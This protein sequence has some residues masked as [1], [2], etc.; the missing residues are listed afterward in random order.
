MNSVELAK[1]VLSKL[2][3]VGFLVTEDNGL[4][5][6]VLDKAGMRQIHEPAVQLELATQQEW[7]ERNLSRYLNFFANGD[8]I[9]PERIDPALVEVTTRQ[10]RDLFRV[11]RLLWSLPFSKGYGRRLRFLLIDQA[12]NKL[13][14]LLALQSPPLSF[15]ARDRLF[16]Y[17]PGRKTELVNQTMDIQTLGAVPPYDY[18]LGGKLVALVAASNEVRQR[19][20]QK[21][22]GRMTEMERRILPPHLVALTTTSAFGRSSLYNRLKYRD[23]AIAE[24]LG[25]TEGYGTFHLMELYPLFR[26]FL[27]SQGISTYG[28]FGTGPRRKWQTMVR[29]LERL[30]FSAEFLRHGIKREVFLFRLIDNLEAYME[31]RDTTPVYRNLPF[32]DLVA[33]WRERW[34]LPRV[35]RVHEWKEWRNEEIKNRLRIGQDKV[36]E[37][38]L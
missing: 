14:G 30:G 1:L 4:C 23:V 27:E 25:Y 7:L 3:E 17:P 24:S 9:I 21:Y 13:I 19:Y 38:I 18:L 10:H 37:V 6:P 36:A 8:D 28:G 2:Q 16:Q 35:E 33:W 15:P 32:S 20:W 22:V 31:G 29:A 12:N 5:M 34:L 11:A 26:E